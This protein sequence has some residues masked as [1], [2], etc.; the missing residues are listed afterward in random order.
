MSILD[1]IVRTKREEIAFR[2]ATEPEDRLR[3]KFPE[4]RPPRLTEALTKEGLNII[5]EVKYRSPSHGPFRC[6]RPPV[7]VAAE[8]VAGGAAALSVLTDQ[9]YF[10]GRLEY[11]QEISAAML[12]AAQ[13]AERGDEA[14]LR[15]WG[16]GSRPLPAVPILRKDFVL[17]RYQITEAAAAGASAYL[18]IVACLQQSELESLLHFGEELELEALVEVHDPFELERAVEAGARLIGV[19]NRNLK[20]FEV[21]IRTSFEL[22]RRLEG[23]T[24][25][26]LVAESGLREGVQLEEL[27]EAGFAGFLIG[28]AFMEDEHPGRALRRLLEGE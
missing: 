19:N 8:Y 4:R 16:D 21:D 22:A 20:T 25:Y 1:E 7:E 6:R 23:E 12:A 28:S 18:L 14:A 24:G 10:D 3:R 9:R 2:K 27:R 26:V 15:R 17:D 13:A 5:A 11:L